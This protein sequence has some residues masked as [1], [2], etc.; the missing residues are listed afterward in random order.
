MSEKKMWKFEYSLNTDDSM[1]PPRVMFVFGAD[2]RAARRDF[3]SKLVSIFTMTEVPN[4][5]P[6]K[7]NGRPDPQRN[8]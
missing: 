7:G 6:R 2:H 8:T 1:T 3:Y 5:A 4:D